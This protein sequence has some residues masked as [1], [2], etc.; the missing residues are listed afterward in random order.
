[1]SGNKRRIRNT[2]LTLSLTGATVAALSL[3][4]TVNTAVILLISLILFI[5]W[6]F[7]VP[8]FVN[9]FAQKAG[10]LFTGR[11]TSVPTPKLSDAETAFKRRN[12]P[13]AFELYSNIQSEYPHHLPVYIPLFQILTEGKGTEEQ[14]EKLYRSGWKSMTGEKREALERIYKEFGSTQKEKYNFYS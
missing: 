5:S 3:D 2:I 12:Y 10:T 11:T 8:P 1:M 14:I 7:V 9:L 13:K 6:D 4:E